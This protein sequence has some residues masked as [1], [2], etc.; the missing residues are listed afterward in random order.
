VPSESSKH[1]IP[2]GEG[3]ISR[4]HVR[5]LLGQAGLDAPDLDMLAV[6][7]TAALE[8]PFLLYLSAAGPTDATQHIERMAQSWHDL[9]ERI[10]RA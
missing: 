8:G 9:V 5:M 1:L 7:L 4:F 6:Q 2:A 3:R 10:C